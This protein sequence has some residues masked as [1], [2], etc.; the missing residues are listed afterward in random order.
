MPVLTIREEQLTDGGFTATLNFDG[1]NSYEITVTE[2]FTPQQ[3]QQLEWYFEQWL[4]IPWLDTVKAESAATS[5][6]SYGENLFEQVFKSNFDAYG[7][8]RDLRK[9]LSQLQIVIESKSPEFQ[10]FHWEA[11]KDPDLSRPLS[12]D[13]IISRKRR[14]ATIVSAQIATSPTINLLVVIA[15]PDEERDVNYRTISR[16]LVEL[17]NNSQ[18]PV[19]ID[20]L[21]PGTYE[22]LTKHLDDKGE[23]YYH[24]IHFDV[25]GGLMSYEQYERGVHPDRLRYQ[26][27]Y[28]LEDLE[29]YQGVKAF[30]FLEGEEKGRATP[31]EATELANLLTGKNIP[32]CILNACQSGKQISQQSEDYRETS[33]GSRLMAAG[34]QAVVAMGYSVTVSAAKLMME[35]VYQQLLAGKDLAD[36]IRKGRLELFNKKQRRAYFNTTID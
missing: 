21:R 11:L 14:G 4:E 1:D 5:V 31:V 32:I 27:G 7:E 2:P 30:L 28:G 10:G 29:P 8:Y 26:R 35:Q 13:C 25:H 12:V 9:Q 36:A 18:I 22:A 24:V 33:L 34:M 23:D 15:R 3:E 16:P 17:V 19:K 20:I 6:Q